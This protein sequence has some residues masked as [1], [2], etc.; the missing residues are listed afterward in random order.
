MI[1]ILLLYFKTPSSVIILF[2]IF[3]RKKLMPELRNPQKAATEALRVWFVNHVSRGT[4][5]HVACLGGLVI[6]PELV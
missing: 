4:E 3:F 2:L 1:F 5:W 6:L